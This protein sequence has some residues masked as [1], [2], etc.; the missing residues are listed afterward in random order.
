MNSSTGRVSSDGR[1]N[2]LFEPSPT[3]QQ[4]FETPSLV[5]AGKL[6]GST[7]GEGGRIDVSGTFTETVMNIAEDLASHLKATV[8]GDDEQGS[9][10]CGARLAR[11][12]QGP[13]HDGHLLEER[14]RR[15]TVGRVGFEPTGKGL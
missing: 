7:P 5:A 3:V 2:Q 12:P 9:Y 14:A 1:A 8:V 13:L 11:A 4:G 15:P 6:L 10:D